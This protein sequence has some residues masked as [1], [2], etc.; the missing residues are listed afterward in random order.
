MQQRV[1]NLGGR[2]NTGGDDMRSNRT[3]GIDSTFARSG[4][5][6]VCLH[7]GRARFP[8]HRT[9]IFRCSAHQTS[10]VR[11]QTSSASICLSD[12]LWYPTKVV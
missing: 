3:V 4:Q 8:G 12:L 1:N 2:S 9:G 10:L 11:R 5:G 6:V 7:E